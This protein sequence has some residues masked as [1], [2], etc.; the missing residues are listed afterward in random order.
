MLVEAV[1]GQGVVSWR[2]LVCGKDFPNKGK[3]L[4]N[5]PVS[6]MEATDDAYELEQRGSV[7]NQMEMIEN[8]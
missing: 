2:C 1:D 7:S 5:K 3:Y 6:F 8:C 4:W